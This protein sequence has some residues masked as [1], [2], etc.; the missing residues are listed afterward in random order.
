MNYTKLKAEGR[1]QTSKLLRGFTLVEIVVTISLSVLLIGSLYGVYLT[2]YKSY[3][4]SINKAELNQNARITLERISRDLRQTERITTS[5]PPDDTDDMNPAP[6]T[7]QFQDGHDTTK[8]QYIKYLLSGNELRRQLIH[9][10]F[11][12]T[13]ETCPETDWVAWNT[14]DQYGN[15]PS[16]WIDP[17]NNVVKADKISSIKFYGIKIITTEVKVKDGNSSY[18]Y[19][20]KTLGRNIQ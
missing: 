13:P 5:L 11:S 2:S 14:Q 3:R 7:I 9:Y 8:V 6:S 19:K 4:R 1:P 15:T 12:S 20:T 10:C 17:A 18:T 16:E